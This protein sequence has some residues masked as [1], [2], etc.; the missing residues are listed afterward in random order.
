M[1]STTI[2]ENNTSGQRDGHVQKGPGYL[3]EY[4]SLWVHSLQSLKNYRETTDLSREKESSKLSN[5]IKGGMKKCAI[6]ARL[7]LLRKCNTTGVKVVK[8]VS[9]FHSKRLRRPQHDMTKAKRDKYLSCVGQL[10]RI[11]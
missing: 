7:R 5:P 11:W 9:Y 1:G 3:K 4:V 10:G 8:V 6:E 2:K